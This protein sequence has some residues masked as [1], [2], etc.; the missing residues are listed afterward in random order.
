MVNID[1]NIYSIVS[2]GTD[3]ARMFEKAIYYAHFS[4][5]CIYLG[6]FNGNI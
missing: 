6:E 3:V 2:V 4:H 1:M 5:G